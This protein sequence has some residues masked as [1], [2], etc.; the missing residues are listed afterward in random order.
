VWQ[1]ARYLNVISFDEHLRGRIRVNLEAHQR[2]VQPLEGRRHAA[3]AIVLVDSHAVRD[4]EIRSWRLT[5]RSCRETPTIARAAR[6]T[7]G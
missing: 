5:C 1:I 3:V 2:L 7:G 6:S 4:D